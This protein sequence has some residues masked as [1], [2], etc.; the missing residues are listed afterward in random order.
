MF[1]VS[2]LMFFIASCHFVISGYRLT[3]V[4]IMG[5]NLAPPLAGL[6]TLNSWD[7]V[8]WVALYVT[9]EI[10]GTGAAIYRCWLIWQRNWKVIVLPCII[11]VGEIVS[12]YACC[13]LFGTSNP[14]RGKLS[15]L[16]QLMMQMFYALAVLG[17]LLPTGLMVYRLWTTHHKSANSGV[18]TPSILYPV[19]RIL[20][21]SASL[22][23]LV[24]VVILGT[25]DSGR[26][27]QF[28]IVPLIVP[29]VV[30]AVQLLI[31]DAEQLNPIL[32]QGITF[33]LI[34]IRIKLVAS[35]TVSTSGGR[36]TYP[37]SLH[38]SNSGWRP[39]H[40]Q[41]PPLHIPSLPSS[42]RAPLSPVSPRSLGRACMWD[43][44]EVLDISAK[45][46]EARAI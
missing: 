22:Q 4:W 38:S 42:P 43:G 35:D 6:Y 31:E 13:A 20:V 2:S 36:T 30:R 29:I 46:G 40:D 45:P 3:Q 26:T 14:L 28:I 32:P 37:S 9:Q 39:K 21:E 1:I 10:F 15:P 19:V 25:F 18:K 5:E 8:L 27:E 23:L 16:V 7:N 34:A 24:E 17:N 11:F 33:S 44:D 41:L 12:G